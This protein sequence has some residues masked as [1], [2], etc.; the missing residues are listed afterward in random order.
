M[1][2]LLKTALCLAL[3]VCMMAS[4]VV[5]GVAEESEA[6]TYTYHMYK[7]ALAT[8]WNPHTWETNL[9]DAMLGYILSPLA[10]MTIDDSENGVCQWI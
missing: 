10:T 9:D 8:N 6:P 2:K 7:S 1:N 3:A 4:M 5:V